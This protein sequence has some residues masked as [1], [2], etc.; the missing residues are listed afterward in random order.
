MTASLAPYAPV[1]VRRWLVDDPATRWQSLDATLVFADISGFTKLSERL[2]RA[3]N[4]GAEELTDTIGRCFNALLRVAYA[5]GGNLLKF[6]GDA[7]LLLFTG[8]GHPERGCRSAIGMRAALRDLGSIAT[9]TGPITLKMSIG[10]HSGPMHAFLVGGSHREFLM[11]GPGPTQTVAMESAADAGQIVVSPAT[12]ALLGPAVLGAP[13]GPGHLLAAEPAFDYRDPAIPDDAGVDDALRISIPVALRAHLE[14]G[15]R[16]AEH[17]RVTIAFLKFKGLD[18]RIHDEG[19][20]ATAAALDGMIRVAQVA[21]ERHDVTF[22]GTDVDAGGGKVLLVAGAPTSGGNDEERMLL[23]LRDIVAQPSSIAFQIGVHAGHVFAGDIGPPYRRSYTVMGDAVNLAARV[24]SRSSPG[25]I[26]A[27][28]EVLGHSRTV[29]EVSQLEPFLVKGKSEPVVASEVGPVIGSRA[30]VEA[31]R[32]ADLP[33]V[34]RHAELSLFDGIL[35]GT[36]AG[37]GHLLEVVG[38]AGIGKSRLVAA[39]RERAVDRR[40]DELVCELHRAS[41][42]YGSVRRLL[43]S[44]LG[45]PTDASPEEA[46]SHL[47]GFL[48]HRL[49]SLLEWAPLLAIAYGTEVPA[50]P[51]T[52]QLDEQFLRPRLQSAVFDLLS[53]VWDGPVL[54]TIEDAQWMDQA[55]ADVLRAV[56]SRLEERPWLVC[57]TRR[58]L[59]ARTADDGPT[60]T[61]VLEPLDAVSAEALASAATDAAPLPAHEMAQLVERSAGNPLFLQELVVAAR[62]AGNGIES[63]PGSVESLIT[64]RID[65]LPAELRDLLRELSVLGYSFPGDLAAAVLGADGTARL[66]RLSDFLSQEQ[67]LIRFRHAMSRDAAYQGLTYRRRRE[68]HAL[69][70]DTIAAGDGDQPELLSFHYHLAA[71][72]ADAWHASLVAGA[73]AATVYANTEAA[74]FYARAVDAGRRLRD[75]DA[76]EVARASEALGD[77]LLRMGEL[78]RADQAYRDAARALRDDPVPWAGVVLKGARIKA[79]LQWYSQALA[80]ITRA[81]R[82]LDDL[83]GPTVNA[84]RA[85]LMVWYSHLRLEQGRADDGIRWSRLAIEEADASNERDALAHAYRLLDWAYAERGQLE[86]AVYSQAGLALYEELGDLP[87]QAN[88]LNNLGVFA[89]W[90]GQWREALEFYERANH[91]EDRVGNVIGAAL[92][93]NNVAEILADQGRWDEADRTFRAAERAVRAAR[94]RSGIAFVRANIGRTAARAGRFDEAQELL[95]EARREALDVGAATQV[96]EAEAR[97]AELHVLR[98]APDEALA[99]V[100][101]ALRRADAKEGVA[102]QEPLLYRVRGYAMLQLGDFEGARAALVRSLDAARSRDADYER[103]LAEHAL[104]E[105]AEVATGQPDRALLAASARTFDALGVERLPEVPRTV[106]VPSR[107]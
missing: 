15:L 10:V 19:P 104:S 65:R 5:D 26:L 36:A 66:G 38:E 100:E 67:G 51:S 76:R 72:Y 23:A 24:M 46:A 87:N 75:L 7:L 34:G 8:E 33:F 74:R 63:L 50:T 82:R 91:I 44:L 37:S 73:R 27:T 54:V 99:I 84:Q 43:R 13:V 31:D 69:A 47:L 21:A 85:Q 12:A 53:A 95:E 98:G 22:L 94:F 52:A 32:Q 11:T 89:Y 2:A 29:F 86:L 96:V 80:A 6:G 81:L 1:F 28:D 58:G 68:L 60:T 55:S 92:G 90:A 56:A 70:G 14:A 41:T 48:A 49:P 62:E 42:P 45:T 64:A 78:E 106:K 71:R 97:L 3:G 107:R 59:D 101:A 83:E 16:D 30:G 103:A 57:I 88:M 4:I 93:R 20:A 40:V 61:L 39:F 9:S 77:A 18:E 79:Q 102:S 35:R 25:V 105:L 17:R